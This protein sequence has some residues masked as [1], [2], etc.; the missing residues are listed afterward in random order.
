VDGGDRCDELHGAAVDHLGRPILDGR[1]ADHRKFLGYRADIRDDLLLRGD[2]GERVGVVGAVFPG[3]GD[4][5][6]GGTD[7]CHSQRGVH[8]TDQPVVVGSDRCDELHGAAIDHVG[9]AVYDCGF[10]GYD[11]LLG[12]GAD[13]GHDLLLR[14]RGGQRVGDVG[15]IQPGVGADV[16]RRTYGR[17]RDRGVGVA[18]Q[19]VLDG[20]G[21]GDQLHGA[22][23]DHVGW[24]VYGCGLARHGELLG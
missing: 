11:Q 4:H 15:P 3:V 6:A 9:G 5:G 7:G 2:R 17:D 16:A 13:R 21:G 1:F 18:D 23:I 14:G 24:A 20:D 10:N 22:A 8:H 12:Y 19:S